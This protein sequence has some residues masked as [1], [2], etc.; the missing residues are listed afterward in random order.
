MDC[1]KTALVS[2]ME[3]TASMAERCRELSWSA[4]ITAETAART[5]LKLIAVIEQAS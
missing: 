3:M 4:N 5:K 2:Q 1:A